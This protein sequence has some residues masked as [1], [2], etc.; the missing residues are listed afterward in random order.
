MNQVLK[1]GVI[2]V[3][4][5]EFKDCLITSFE[6]KNDKGTVKFGYESFIVWECFSYNAVGKLAIIHDT[7]KS[8][9]NVNILKENLD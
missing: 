9:Q 3:K 1:L 8:E 6:P 2:F 5:G 7:F 4:K